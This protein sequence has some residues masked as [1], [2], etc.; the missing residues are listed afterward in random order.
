M[1]AKRI[2]FLLAVAGVAVSAPVMMV[3]ALDAPTAN[4]TE[5]WQTNASNWSLS[6]GFNPTN[7]PRNCWSTN[8][9]TLTQF[10]RTGGAPTIDRFSG[11]TN[12]STGRFAGDYVLRNIESVDFDVKSSGI[13]SDYYPRLYFKYA[14]PG[15]TSRWNYAAA[16]IPCDTGTNWVHVSIPMAFSASWENNAY[17][18]GDNGTPPEA[19]ALFNEDK[20][21]VVE[22]NVELYSPRTI[23]AES[24]SVANMKL[25]GPWSGPYTNGISLAFLEEYGLSIDDALADRSHNGSQSLLVDFLSC[26]NPNDS[27]DVFRLVIGRGA[28]G[29]PRLSWPEKNKYAKYD[30]LEGSDLADSNSFNVVSGHSN[31]TGSGTQEVADVSSPSGP[32]YYKVQ[33]RLQ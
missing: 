16:V 9:L 33:I 27:N 22:I 1:K 30:L 13:P 10:A 7:V 11:S 28:G 6:D 24:L 12:A 26:S 5:K 32:R 4:L 18:W 23:P 19:A 25:I 2:Q 21:C 3:Q 29:H 8:R 31:H 15:M 17:P 20:A 14:K